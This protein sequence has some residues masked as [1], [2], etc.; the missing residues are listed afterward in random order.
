MIRAIDKQLNKITMYRLVLYYLILLLI[1]AGIYSLLGI[2]SFSLISLLISIGILLGVSLVT[3]KIFATVFHAPTNVESVYITALILALIISPIRT[4]ADIAIYIWAPVLA[5][6]T[7]YILAI[8]K[9]HLFNP[10]AIAVVLTAIGFSG[11]A[12]WW[13]GTASMLPFVLLGVLIVRKIR[14]FDLV[15]YFFVG[16]YVTILLFSFLDKSDLLTN[17]HDVTLVSALFFFAFIMLTEPLTTPPTKL[18]QSIY[19]FIVGVMFVPF[20]HVGNFYTTPEIALVIG[21][22]FSYLVSSKQKIFVKLKNRIRTS[23]NT[24]DIIFTPQKKLA[25]LP[26]QYMEWTLPHEQTDS[27]GNRRYFTIAS[28]PTE[29]VMRLGVKIYDQGSSYKKALM[30]KK[31]AV[32]VGADLKGDFTLPKDKRKKLVFIAGG[33]G[34]TPFRSMMKYLIDTGENRKITLF[35]S[36]KHADEI[37]YTDVFLQAA[38]RPGFKIIYTLTDK[39]NAPPDWDG[40]V[41]R[42]DAGMIKKYVPDFN[43]RTFYI[44]GPNAMVE[45]FDRILEGMGIQKK[46]I[47]KDFFAGL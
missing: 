47:K 7:K 40:N 15:Y 18:L 9:K 46:H 1:V 22:V 37:I 14:R 16:V 5:V 11:T 38:S 6:A 43:D 23:V 12:S 26:G 33:V 3:N 42:I 2:L 25:Y 36:N 20:F 4:G 29:K 44:S 10:A 21:N 27:R 19:G 34:I 41:G 17:V 24:I 32:F 28:S 13:I 35:Y 31:D 45:D 30:Q 39:E 8:Y